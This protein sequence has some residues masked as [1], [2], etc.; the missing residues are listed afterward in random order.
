MSA[1]ANGYANYDPL[2]DKVHGRLG[3]ELDD[4]APD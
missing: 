2:F 1:S 4:S 3:G